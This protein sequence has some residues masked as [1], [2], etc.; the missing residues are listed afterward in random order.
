[1]K[2]RAFR[3]LVAGLLALAAA[4]ARA[5]FLSGE[6]LDTV[7]D[8][9]AIFILFLVPVVGIVLF[10]LVH[11]LPEKIAEKRH[12]PQTAA[13]TT[14]CLLSLVFGGLL[15]PLAW[16]WAFTKPVGYRVAYGTDKGDEYFDEMAEKHR[17][18]KLLR[19]EAFHLREE[20]ESMEARGALPPRLRGLKDQLASL[21]L[22]EAEARAPAA[23]KPGKAA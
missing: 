14:L 13:I 23:T 3:L 12:H 6:A 21:R 2:N 18:G 16:L 7:A 19:E 17:E 4:P 1:M 5:S 8:I 10:W 9:L 11:V 15:W 22:A 20:L